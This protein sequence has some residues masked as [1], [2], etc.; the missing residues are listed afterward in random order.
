MIISLKSVRRFRWNDKIWLIA[1]NV[2]LNNALNGMLRPN[3]EMPVVSISKFGFAVNTDLI[4]KFISLCV[5]AGDEMNSNIC[6]NCAGC[7][8]DFIK[9]LVAD[10]AFVRDIL[11][12][13]IQNNLYHLSIR[14]VDMFSEH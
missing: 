12:Q 10:T 7:E 1:C 6:W 13:T 11:L 14:F 2:S 8:N 9:L 3:S 5:G 4:K